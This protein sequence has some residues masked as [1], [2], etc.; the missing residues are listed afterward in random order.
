MQGQ[1][2]LQNGLKV[3]LLVSLNLE[4]ASIIGRCMGEDREP[5]ICQQT[6]PAKEQ[7]NSSFVWPSDPSVMIRAMDQ[8]D[9][10]KR[11][12]DLSRLPRHLHNYLQ[13]GSTLEGKWGK[14]ITFE[15]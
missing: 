5:C 15:M 3:H 8:S 10:C 12:P 13:D 9:K 11:V 14:G 4:E 1:H 6:N 7:G 2:S